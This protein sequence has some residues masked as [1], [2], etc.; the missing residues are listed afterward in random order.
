MVILIVSGFAPSLTG[1]R[2]PFLHALVRAGH[3]VHATAPELAPEIS[4]KL[5]RIGVTYHP[6]PMSRSGLSLFTD[7]RY[8]WALADLMRLIKAEGVFAYTHKPV[9]HALHAAAQEGV[10]HRVAMITGLGYA[11]TFGGGLRRKIIRFIVTAF[12]RRALPLA[13]R[14]FFQN[15]DDLEYFRKLS[16]LNGAPVPKVVAGSGVPLDEYKHF[17]MPTGNPVFLMLARLLVDKGVREYAQAAFELRKKHPLARCLLA[18]EY[19][20]NPAAITKD[21]VAA[22]SK[23]GAIEYLG[24]LDDV[25]PALQVCTAFVLPSYR[26]GTPRSTLEALATGRPIITTDAPGCRETILNPLPAQPDGIRRGDNGWL[27]PVADAAALLSA[28][29]EFISPATNR[30]RL[31]AASRHH[32][33]SKYD[34]RKVNDALLSAFSPLQ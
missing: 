13:T 29:E 23:S 9:I 2:F 28:M 6:I 22:W 24:K 15:S 27:V 19:D 16:L 21:E 5:S 20:S 12:Y 14:L 8:R 30:E 1:F 34:V 3:T 17:P 18:G 33:E 4:E 26:E 32:A 25:R 10:R 11:F 31:G 7:W